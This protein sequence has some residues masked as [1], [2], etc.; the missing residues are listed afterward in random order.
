LL[1]L[2]FTATAD[3]VIEYE[4]RVNIIDDDCWCRP[5]ELD[6]GDS[7]SG[8]L[9][10]DTDTA[11]RD[12]NPHPAMSEFDGE[13][14]PNRNFVVG[15]HSLI[16]T[17]LRGP[18]AVGFEDEPPEDLYYEGMSVRDGI[19]D[20]TR[21]DGIWLVLG[22]GNRNADLNLLDGDGLEQSFTAG[23]D[24]ENGVRTLGEL[25]R[26]TGAFSYVVQFVIERLSVKPRVCSA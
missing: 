16:A 7:V 8:S 10:I 19:G 24:L 1:A 12:S 14:G 9:I 17:D 5:L 25:R 11:P 21:G 22:L 18:D 26:R 2:T 13:D 6:V 15:K 4:G 20:P 23:D 3:V